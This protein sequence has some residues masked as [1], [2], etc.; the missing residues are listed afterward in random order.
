MCET[1][2][3]YTFRELLNVDEVR[4][5]LPELSDECDTDR[6]LLS[7]CLMLMRNIHFES[8]VGCIRP[9]TEQERQEFTEVYDTLNRLKDII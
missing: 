7:Q 5:N 3:R 9:F 8:C 4:K 6:Q 2:E 1:P